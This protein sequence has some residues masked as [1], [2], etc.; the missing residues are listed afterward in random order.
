MFELYFSCEFWD[1]RG[2]NVG[3]LWVFS[4]LISNSVFPDGVLGLKLCCG[5]FGVF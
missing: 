1:T 5:L 4:L 3:L 2:I